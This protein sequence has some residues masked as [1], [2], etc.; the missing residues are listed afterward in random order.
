LSASTMAG[1]RVFDPFAG[2]ASTGV[3]ALQI[4]RRFVG[5]EV[6]AEFATLARKRLATADDERD[7]SAPA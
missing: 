7:A 1:D 5:C 2:S 6:D 4:N 3:A